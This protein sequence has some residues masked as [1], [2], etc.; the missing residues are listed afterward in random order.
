MTKNKQD[1]VVSY[2]WKGNDGTVSTVS[3]KPITI[4][5]MAAGY[6]FNQDSTGYNYTANYDN[7]HGLLLKTTNA[8]KSGTNYEGA[9]F[10]YTLAVGAD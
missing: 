5:S 8:L 3:D 9:T 1:G 10:D 6:Q 2:F 4:W 7:D